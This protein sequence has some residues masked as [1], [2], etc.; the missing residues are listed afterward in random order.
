MADKFIHSPADM[1]SQP[2]AGNR[3]GSGVYDGD[4]QAPLSGYR[5]THSPNAVPEKLY[6]GTLPSVE[7]NV[8]LPNELPKNQK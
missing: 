6:D 5:R 7:K 4:D 1:I 8:T 2:P 3:G